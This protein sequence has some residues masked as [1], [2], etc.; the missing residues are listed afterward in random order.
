MAKKIMWDPGHGGSDPGAAAN[1]LQ[2]EHLT[3]KIVNYAVAY[4]SANYTDFEQRV[5]RGHEQTLP[6]GNRDD[7]ADAWG[8]NVFVS[9]HINAGGGTGFESYVYTSPGPSASA[10]QNILHGEILAAMR[11]F[12]SIADRGKKR[13]NF[14]VLRETNMDAVLTEN[15]FIDNTNDANKLKN[16]AFLK[17]VGEGHA[18]GV[19]K[20]LGLPAKQG[21]QPAPAPAPAPQQPA[22]PQGIG[23][24]KV[25][26]N[27]V[28]RDK[29]VYLGNIMGQV[30][31]GEE[32]IVHD[33][34]TGWFNIGGWVS[35]QHVQFMPHNDTKIIR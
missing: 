20:F 32:Y 34:Q 6:L 25:L 30:A 18:R 1:G 15:L 11:Q 7:A 17:A 19:A 22:Q 9:V 13:A 23:I 35:A 33:Y 31:P 26:S 28:I 10:L 12:G 29:P 3:L 4:M 21:S 5:T 2:E 16:E 27:T 24:L 8:A 14:A